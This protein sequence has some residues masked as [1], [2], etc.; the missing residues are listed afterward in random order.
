MSHLN[1]FCRDLGGAGRPPMVVLHGML[2]S[3]RNWQTAGAAL[4]A[5]H[6]VIALD[7]RNHGASPHSDEMTYDAMVDDVAAWLESRGLSRAVWMGHSMGGKVAMLLACRHP[8]KV[9]RLVVV[10]IAPKD[11]FWPETREQFAAMSQLDLD[12][13]Q[14]RS[15]AEKIM[16]PR[17][18]D[19]ALRKFL[20]TNL[21]RSAAGWRWQV[22]LPVLTRVLP[23][24]E[25]SPLGPDD[26]FAGPALFL[27]GGKSRYVAAGDEALIARHFPSGR[28]KI[29]PGAGHNPHLDARDAFVS[30]VA[31]F[32]SSG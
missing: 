8:R 29:I 32:T 26:R 25:K 16:E 20:L 18:P 21:E 24:L 9:D 4:A 10:D 28:L 7:L 2:G 12:R 30:A 17:V 14:S 1:L 3:S 11:Y 13:L 15:E 19:W 27:A 31:E 22:N 5:H 23:E 6:H